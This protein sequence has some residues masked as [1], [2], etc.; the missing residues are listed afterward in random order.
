[1]Q[2]NNSAITQRQR[3]LTS[4]AIWNNTGFYDVVELSNAVIGNFRFQ[5]L[6]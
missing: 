4:Q 5:L 2:N 6:S 1:M 3:P